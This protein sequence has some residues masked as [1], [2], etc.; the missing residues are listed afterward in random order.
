MHVFIYQPINIVRYILTV[1]IV[2]PLSSLSIVKQQRPTLVNIE[3]EFS[4]SHKDRRL[5]VKD[6]S[7]HY[8]K[9]SNGVDDVY[10]IRRKPLY[11]WPTLMLLL[12]SLFCNNL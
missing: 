11:N 1:S 6:W 2:E 12:S 4:M 10:C 8:H 5:E 9:N 3:S 7:A